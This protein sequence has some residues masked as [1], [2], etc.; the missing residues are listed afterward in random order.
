[1]HKGNY[2]QMDMGCKLL[3]GDELPGEWKDIL[4]KH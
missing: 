2:W 4:F 1:M 3:G